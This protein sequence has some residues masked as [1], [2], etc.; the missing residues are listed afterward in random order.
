ME[1]NLRGR[2]KEVLP[3]RKAGEGKAATGFACP[4]EGCNQVCATKR[5]LQS[6]L[7]GHR[8]RA[9][10]ALVYSDKVTTPCLALARSPLRPLAASPARR[11]ADAPSLGHVN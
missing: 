6:H 11:F 8:R 2:S 7:G 10:N 4:W 1:E 3:E 9:K 5:G